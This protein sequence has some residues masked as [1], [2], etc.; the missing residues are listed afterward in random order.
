M[1]KTTLVLIALTVTLLVS[2]AVAQNGAIL[3]TDHRTTTIQPAAGRTQA[4]KPLPALSFAYNSIATDNP[5]GYYFCCE[6]YTVSGAA[7][8]I[9]ESIWVAQGFT[10][11]SSTTATK[12]AVQIS[13]VEGTYTDVILSLNADCSGVPCSTSLAQTT[14]QLD[15]SQVFGACCAYELWSKVN[16]ALTG[17]SQYWVVA[18]TESASDVWGAWNIEVLD[19][20]DTSNFAYNDAGAGWTSYS[21]T[22]GAATAVVQ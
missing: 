4:T 21:T 2:N 17:G 1:S 20:V 9:G 11:A 6:G 5:K 8:A 12:I 14:L 19:A 10:P 22:E 18:S 15:T 13:Y 3:S 16:V 7:S